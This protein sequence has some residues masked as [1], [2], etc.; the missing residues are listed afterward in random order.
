MTN[1][2]IIDN[3]MINNLETVGDAKISTTQ[4]KF[5][6]S[7]MFFDGFGDYLTIPNSVNLQ[8]GTGDFTVEFW[9][10]VTGGSSW[11]AFVSKGAADTGW[12]VII[13]NTGYW[14]F[15]DT[16]NNY[17]GS[18]A[19][20]NNSWTHIAFTR[21]GT[22]VKLFVN[23]TQALSTTLSTNFNQTEQMVIGAGRDTTIPIT[24]YIDDLRI[25][26]GVARYTT[27]FTP[28]TAAFPTQ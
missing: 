27:T 24:G 5:G 18:V 20:T 6:G 25:T 15:S 13:N 9:A 19:V 7:S 26:K 3:T 22:T 14:A 28:P 4:S 2:G 21:S 16:G 11:R 12:S 17:G 23:G 1:A 10:Y 8:F